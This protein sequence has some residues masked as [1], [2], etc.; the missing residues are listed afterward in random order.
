MLIILPSI[1]CSQK[2]GRAIFSNTNI[3]FLNGK[4]ALFLAYLIFKHIRQN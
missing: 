4:A 2:L 1:P 3:S